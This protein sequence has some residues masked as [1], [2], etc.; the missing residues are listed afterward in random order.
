[1]KKNK[2]TLLF[3]YDFLIYKAACA[4]EKKTIVAINKDT[5][6]E[7]TFNNRSEF[8]GRGKTLGGALLQINEEESKNYTKDDFTILDKTEVESLENALALTKRII[9]TICKTLGTNRY[10]GYS[11][12]GDTF[13]DKLCTLKQYKGNR[14]DLIK[15][16]WHKEVQ[17]YLVK[18]H[19]CELITEV[20]ADDAVATDAWY[21]YHQ[22]KKT[23]ENKVIT[24]AV[25]KDAKGTTGFLY[26]PNKDFEPLEISGLG[27][28]YLNEKNEVDGY[29]RAWWYFQVIRGDDI[30]NYDPACLSKM[31]VG[32]KTAYKALKDCKTD[33]EYWQ[34][35]V[36]FYKKMYPE[37]V[38]FTNFRGNKLTVDWLY[39]LQEMI[40]LS[41]MR[42]WEDDRVIAT[43]VLDKLRINY[44]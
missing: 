25:D 15:P 22:F 41:W 33:R 29:G 12:I 16:V 24:I 34:A 32:D 4:V 40:D 14:E 38:T 26:N 13:R 5:G 7:L 35:I 39:I 42:R 1:M 20:E 17:E 6:Q 18:Y 43:E 44:G 10:Y 11:G 3:D 21:Y 30:D 37:P 31:R 2:D 36:D 9:T 27:E 23:G 19:N 8:W 28:L